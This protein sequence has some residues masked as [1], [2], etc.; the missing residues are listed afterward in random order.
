[1]KLQSDNTPME[2]MIERGG[3]PSRTLKLERN[4]L[5]SGVYVLHGEKDNV[6]PT[7]IAR[8]MRERLGKFHNDFTYYEYPD[9]THWYGNHSVDWPPIFDF[10]KQ[11]TIKKDKEVKKLEFFTGSPG[12]SAKI[13]FYN[14][15]STE[16]NLLK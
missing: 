10:F 1:M 14:D 8:E 3:T 2:N 12:V 13:A 6:V 15:T 7:A 11:R 4:Y 16:K 5:Q 9:G